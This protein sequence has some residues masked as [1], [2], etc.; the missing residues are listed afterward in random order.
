MVTYTTSPTGKRVPWHFL[1]QPYLRN[2]D[3]LVCPS[4]PDDA[5][6]SH[7]GGILGAPATVYAGYGMNDILNW[8]TDGTKMMGRWEVIDGVHWLI[9]RVKQSELMHPVDTIDFGD[10]SPPYDFWVFNPPDLPGATATEVAKRH[11]EGANFVFC[12]GHA[13]WMRQTE[14]RNWR[15]ED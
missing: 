10:C 11:Q 14:E 7:Y 15:V 12:D 13:K 6:A 2:W 4:E 5:I 9:F 8:P 1:A 3:I